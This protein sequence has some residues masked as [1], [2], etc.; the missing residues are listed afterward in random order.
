MKQH[1]TIPIFIPEKACPFRCVY[2]NQYHIADLIKPMEPEAILTEVDRY[3]ETIPKHAVK[4][5]AFFGGSFTGMSMAEQERYLQVVFPYL[6]RG[7]ISG[8]Q[9]SMRPDYIN[10]EI[11]QLLKNYGVSIIEL[12]AQ[13]LDDEVLHAA[14]RG[15]TAAEVQQASSL[16]IENGFQLGLQMMIG[17]PGDTFEKSIDTAKKIIEWGAH[18]TRIYPALVIRDTELEQ[19]YLQKKYTPLTLDEAIHWCRSLMDLFTA[20]N[21]TI[22]RMGLHPSEGL[23]TGHNLVAGP[24]HVSF[25]EL[26]QTAHWNSVLEQETQNL[27]TQITVKVNRKQLNSA[28]GYYGKNKKWLQQKYNKVIFQEDESLLEWDYKIEI[29]T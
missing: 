22:L 17:L 9:L 8:I 25:K 6:E 1:Y 18:Y 13:S 4:R 14:G 23:L 28:V 26:V 12:G 16:I 2:C 21:I 29:T 10:L 20:Q 15:H 19:M 27:G 11:L 5:I 7:D 24:F 3:L